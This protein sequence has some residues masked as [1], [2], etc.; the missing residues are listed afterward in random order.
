MKFLEPALGCSQHVSGG[1][2][3]RVAAQNFTL[4]EIEGVSCSMHG[5]VLHSGNDVEA[6]LLEAQAHTTCS[7][8]EVDSDGPG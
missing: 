6:S 4:R 2:F 1:E 7:G 3:G 8:E 5:V